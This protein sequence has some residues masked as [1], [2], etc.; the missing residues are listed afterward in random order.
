MH[1]LLTTPIHHENLSYNSILE[2]RFTRSITNRCEVIITNIFDNNTNKSIHPLETATPEAK[3][4]PTSKTSTPLSYMKQ[5][6]KAPSTPQNTVTQLR[7]TPDSLETPPRNISPNK[8]TSIN[9]EARCL[10][11]PTLSLH[12]CSLTRAKF[13]GS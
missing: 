2:P 9:S 11:F 13:D 3:S 10:H 7:I 4:S 12:F 6:I 5:V 1:S 8:E